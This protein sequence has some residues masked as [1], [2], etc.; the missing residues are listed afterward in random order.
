MTTARDGT[1]PILENW[2]IYKYLGQ[3]VAEGDIFND[4]RWPDG[5]HVYTSAI[6]SKNGDFLQTRNTLY[7]LGKRAAKKAMQ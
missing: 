1:H 2:K 7:L 6:K 4:I 3:K 5:T